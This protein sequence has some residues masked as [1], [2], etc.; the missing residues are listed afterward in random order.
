MGLF[1]GCIDKKLSKNNQLIKLA[2]LID[3]HPI[4]AILFKVH[5]R[6]DLVRSVGFIPITANNWRNNLRYRYSSLRLNPNSL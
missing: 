2:L 6:D 5:K 1:D 4:R 3:C